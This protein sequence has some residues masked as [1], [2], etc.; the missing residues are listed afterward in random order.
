[1]SYGILVDVTRCTG[2]ERCTAAC[3]EANKKDP[4]AAERDR[5][6]A[7]D[8][9]SANRPS[10]VLP[11]GD[12][13][14]AR[15]ACM[16]CLEPS[17]VAACLVGAIKK[18]TAG[19]VIY[20]AD[21]CIGCRYCML[22]CPIHIPRY[23]W[24]KVVPYMVKCSMCTERLRAGEAQ[25]ACVAACPH[26]ALQFGDRELLVEKAHGLVQ[27]APDH[28]LQHVWGEKEWGGTSV[29]YVSDVDLA[30]IGWPEGPSVAIP[31]IT[32]PVIHKTPVLAGSVFFGL[33][34][35]SAIVARR[36]RLMGP[37]ESDKPTG[38]PTDTKGETHD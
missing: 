22:A 35:V 37:P 7:R 24:E 16:H 2:C 4:V 11:A 6:L 12:G 25:P 9:L 32:D 13:R 34:A 33:W 3:V 19:A 1:M 15:K 14:F 21:K 5:A 26:G 36:Q 27:G 31:S 17:C 8:G 38:S 30:S 20:E 10:T 18:T 28:Y 29:L 23:E